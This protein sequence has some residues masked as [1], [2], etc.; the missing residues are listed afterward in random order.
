MQPWQ[1]PSPSGLQLPVTPTRLP[2]L[3]TPQ[4]SPVQPAEAMMQSMELDPRALAPREREQ[5]GTPE[6]KRVPGAARVLVV[7]DT[8][9]E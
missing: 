4:F 2:P 1:Q 8:N 9:V 6:A 3:L 5:G 7:D